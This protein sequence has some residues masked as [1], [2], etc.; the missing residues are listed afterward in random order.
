MIRE[1]QFVLGTSKGLHIMKA[2]KNE[3]GELNYKLCPTDE[4][5]DPFNKFAFHKHRITGVTE[6]EPDKVLVSV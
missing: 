4:G 6:F 1:N 3:K 5:Y 2:E